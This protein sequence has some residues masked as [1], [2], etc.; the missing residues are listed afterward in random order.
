MFFLLGF[1]LGDLIAW[2][3]RRADDDDTTTTTILLN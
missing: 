2:A 3:M 1:A